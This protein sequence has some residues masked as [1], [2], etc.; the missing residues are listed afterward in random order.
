[1]TDGIA[2]SI[3]LSKHCLLPFSVVVDVM[4]HLEEELRLQALL[5]LGPLPGGTLR[6]GGGGG[7]SSCA[8]VV[9]AR[10]REV[11]EPILPCQDPGRCTPRGVT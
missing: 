6:V 7:R 1:V 11:A 2:S 10:R 8:L 3:S 9:T 5:L 4:G